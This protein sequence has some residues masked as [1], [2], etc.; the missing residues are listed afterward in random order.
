MSAL[1]TE[2]SRKRAALKV[3][4]QLYWFFHARNLVQGWQNVDSAQMDCRSVGDDDRSPSF[5]AKPPGWPETGSISFRIHP[6][7]IPE[8][9]VTIHAPHLKL[10][11]SPII[12]LNIG[13]ARDR[14]FY[15]KDDR[16]R[17]LVDLVNA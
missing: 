5:V 11:G 12:G 1:K 13:W 2:L 8:A 7:P 16:G 14:G 3:V 9:D 10:D 17:R 4:R 6:G 15:G